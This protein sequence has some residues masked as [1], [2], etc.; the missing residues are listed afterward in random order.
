MEE[1]KALYQLI[2][3]NLTDN[4][5]LP[6]D[7]YLP[8]EDGNEK[9]KFVNG[10]MDG[11]SIYHMGFSPLNDEESSELER[12]IRLA[13]GEKTKEAEEGFFAFCKSHRA[14]KIIDALQ[15]FIMDHQNELSA[16]IMHAFATDMMFGSSYAECVKIGMSILELFNTYEDAQLADAIRTIGACDEFTIFSVFL[17]RGWPDAN[18]EILGLAKKV[19]GWGR[20]HCVDFIEPE[21]DEIKEWLLENGVDNDIMPAYS[22]Y[23]VFEKA[24]IDSLIEKNDLTK[25]QLRNILKVIDAMLDE[26]PISGISNLED[27]EEFLNKVLTK[28]EEFSF[29]EEDAAILEHIR[30]WKE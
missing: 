13:A 14:V 7:F 21:S 18:K 30:K 29:D 19:R 27:P 9:P 3:E 20:I 24:Q 26:G 4:G 25:E 17:M 15:G 10:A 2:M 22:G 6:E 12:L 5:T 8:S 28:T 23:R 11:I 1:K 16:G